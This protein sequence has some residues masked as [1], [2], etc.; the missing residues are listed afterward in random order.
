LIK[1][2]Y[3]SYSNVKIIGYH[4]NLGKA[5]ALKYG[6]SQIIQDNKNTDLIIGFMD[7]DSSIDPNELKLMIENFEDLTHKGFVNSMSAVRKKS[8]KNNIERNY[9]R[10]L[11]GRMIHFILKLRVKNIPFDTQC[12]LKLFDR[13]SAEIFSRIKFQT[14]WLFEIEFLKHIKNNGID[15][16]IM[17]Y[18]LSYWKEINGS[19]V[20]SLAN[21][22]N[23]LTDLHSIYFR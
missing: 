3:L 17:E 15:L 1:S 2:H 4:K 16:K 23:I 7:F 9:I 10:H 12:G 18:E 19:K 11:I 8:S 22:K 5:Q 13:K 6:F 21:I 20:T 14:R